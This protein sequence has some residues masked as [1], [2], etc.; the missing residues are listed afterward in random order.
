MRAVFFRVGADLRRRWPAL[1]AP[2]IIV[3]VVFG[4][5]L[6]FAA[7]AHRTSTSTAR[8]TASLG[9]DFS[10]ALYQ[11]TGRPRTEEIRRVAAAL[12]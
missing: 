12:G 9:G 4:A 6:A 10:G 1:I 5:V 3:S 11:F 2:T 7:G 8:F